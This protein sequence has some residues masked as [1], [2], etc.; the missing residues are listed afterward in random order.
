MYTLLV[1]S[2]AGAVLSKVEIAVRLHVLNRRFNPVQ[3]I[4]NASWARGSKLID[5][6]GPGWGLEESVS[7]GDFKFCKNHLRSVF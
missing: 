7:W 3:E 5:G 1:L 6:G 2:V 4:D